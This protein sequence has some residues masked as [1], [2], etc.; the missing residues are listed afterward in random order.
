MDIAAHP[1]RCGPPVGNM[2]AFQPISASLSTPA[3]RAKALRLVGA[4]MGRTLGYFQDREDAQLT[5]IR[6]HLLDLAD[7]KLQQLQSQNLR[8]AA[9]LLDR[10]ADA[11]K[12]LYRDAL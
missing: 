1:P 2:S 9:L 7:S 5:Q 11:F 8:T 4:M 3:A 6:S 10:Q 12:R